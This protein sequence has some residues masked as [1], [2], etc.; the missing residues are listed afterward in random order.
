MYAG[1]R[2]WNERMWLNKGTQQRCSGEF[3]SNG[4]GPRGGRYA[5]PDWC[6]LGKRCKRLEYHVGRGVEDSNYQ[7]ARRTPARNPDNHL[8]AATTI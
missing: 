7:S 1:W 2:E 3:L 5:N 8:C 4:M 6:F